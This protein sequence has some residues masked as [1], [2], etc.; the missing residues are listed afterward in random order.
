MLLGELIERLVLIV[1]IDDVF[2]ETMRIGKRIVAPATRGISVARDVESMAA[3]MFPEPG[4]SKQFVHH[5]GV[6]IGRIICLKGLDLPDVG[7]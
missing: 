6:G 5:L 7:R 2:P 4:G 3:P 1:A